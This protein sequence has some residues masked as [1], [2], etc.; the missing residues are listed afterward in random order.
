MQ[1]QEIIEKAKELR[2]IMAKAVEIAESLQ[3]KVPE[4]EEPAMNAQCSVIK[5]FLRQ[6]A[7]HEKVLADM[8]TARMAG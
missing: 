6:T 8:L 2:Q 7:H 4:M 5:A 1:A 3:S